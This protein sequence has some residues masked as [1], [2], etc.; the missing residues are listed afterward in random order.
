M[1]TLLNE[2]KI[3]PLNRL[4]LMFKIQLLKVNGEREVDLAR[5][6]VF[7]DVWL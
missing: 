3:S 5:D 4:K 7:V 6:N 2:L 1:L